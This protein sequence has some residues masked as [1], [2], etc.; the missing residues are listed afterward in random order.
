MYR[1]PKI[2]APVAMPTGARKADFYD[3]FADGDELAYYDYRRMNLNGS[4][5]YIYTL[6][7][8]LSNEQK[9]KY[10]TAYNNVTF[11]SGHAEYT[12]EQKRSYIFVADRRMTA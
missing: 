12:P 7:K 5:G 6:C 10:I 3:L 8:A 4:T 2:N 11:L 9:Q 1:L